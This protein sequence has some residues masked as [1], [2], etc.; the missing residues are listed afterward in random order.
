MQ[1][2]AAIQPMENATT[3]NWWV[4]LEVLAFT[5][6]A[7]GSRLVFA[8]LAWEYSGPMSLA[9]TLVVLTL[10]QRSRGIGWHD[11]GLIRLPGWKAKA[12]VLPKAIVPFA[13]FC[14]AVALVL[15]VGEPLGLERTDTSGVDARWGAIEGNLPLLLTWLAIVWTSAAFGEEM[16]FRGYMVTRLA[17]GLAGVPGR[18]AIA[19]LLP[20]FLF[21]YAHY[22]YQGLFGLVM[23]GLIGLAFGIAFLLLKRNL[24]PLVL[25]HGMIDTINYVAIYLGEK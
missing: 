18:L 21:G 8:E 10:Y 15:F 1:T 25:V 14:V 20:A 11:M 17:D 3:A 22:Y 12:L 9:L 7:F 24:W 13:L 19:V 16:L 4:V 2:N 23:T 5:A 6:L